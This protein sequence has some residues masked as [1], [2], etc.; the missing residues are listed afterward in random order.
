MDGRPWRHRHRDGSVQPDHALAATYDT[1]EAWTF[2]EV[3]RG[4]LSATD[5]VSS[6]D[7]SRPASP[8]LIGLI[9]IS[10]PQRAKTV[11]AGS[12]REPRT[13]AADERA[14]DGA[15]FGRPHRDELTVRRRVGEWRKVSRRTA[16]APA[17]GRA[18]RVRPGKGAGARLAAKSSVLD[19]QFAST[20]RQGTLYLLSVG[21]THT[22]DAHVGVTLRLR[23]TTRAVD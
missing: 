12:E 11:Y 23:V 4:R 18:Q 20:L 5:G 14:S 17:G 19:G 16:A 7:R 22:T 6:G 9:G 21:V 8:G 3:A 1:S 15:G 10:S 2:G 13:N